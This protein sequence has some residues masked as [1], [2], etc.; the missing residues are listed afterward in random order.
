MKGLIRKRS[1]RVLVIILCLL[2]IL[3]F[4]PAGGGNAGSFL[5]SFVITPVQ[6]LSA[7]WTGCHADTAPSQ[8]SI[9]ELEEEIV[10]LNDMLADYYGMKA[11]NEEFHKFYGIKKENTDFSVVTASVI[12]RSP[13]ENFYGFT[14]D[15]G[16][17]D[18][19]KVN[20]TVM[21]EKGLVGW[22][23]ETAPASCIVKTLLSPDT[24][25]GASVKR[26]SDSGI[27][28]GSAS[29]SDDGLTC[30]VNIPAENRLEKGDI[31]VTSGYGGIFPKNI[32]IG[33]VSCISLDGL[34]GM[35]FAVIEPF[36][37]LRTVSSVL[38]VTD[39]D[40]KR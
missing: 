3:S 13:D 22:V 33:K 37:E 4:V 39:F 26:T 30:L 12:G 36:E 35:P 23:C 24:H 20:D 40:K 14:L 29:V 1:L 11:E 21:T 38:I 2:S 18:G 31:A 27:I 32:K 16:S 6:R 25:I 7:G 10:R 19:V 5:A 8:K 9:E 34:T 15:R 17:M 28:T